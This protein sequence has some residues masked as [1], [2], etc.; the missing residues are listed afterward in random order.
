MA[1]TAKSAEAWGGDVRVPGR[2]DSGGEEGKEVNADADV[3][4]TFG[5]VREARILLPT[6]AGRDRRE[7]D[8]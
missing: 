6:A 4:C 1:A 3:G 5:R 7:S 8:G 2:D